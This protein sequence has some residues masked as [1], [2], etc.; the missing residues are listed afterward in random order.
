MHVGGGL[1]T[2][3]ARA[4]TDTPSNSP[5]GTDCFDSGVLEMAVGALARVE[6]RTEIICLSVSK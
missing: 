4:V 2:A 5:F 6:P 1:P 3:C